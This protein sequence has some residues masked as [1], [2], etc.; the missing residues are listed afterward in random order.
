MAIGF[1][2]Y[3]NNQE[4]ILDPSIGELQYV[5]YEWGQDENNEEYVSRSIIPSY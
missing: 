1:T 2:A 4:I 5:A 3:D